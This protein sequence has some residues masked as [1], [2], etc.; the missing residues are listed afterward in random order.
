LKLTDNNKQKILIE[1]IED[2]EL[3]KTDFDVYTYGTFCGIAGT[4][5]AKC[6]GMLELVSANNYDQLASWLKSINP[7]LATYG[8]IGLKFLKI[9]NA[10][11]EKPELQR[12]TELSVSE[13]QLNTCQGGIVGVT[14]KIKDVLKD[15]NINQIYHLFQQ[16][17]WLK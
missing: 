2:S 8:Y 4:P 15:K 13:I 11:I 9:K 1:R 10:K 3:E 17:G 5:P 7:E 16:S 6:Q 14:E 12:M